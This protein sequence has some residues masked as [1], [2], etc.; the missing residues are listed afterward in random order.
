MLATILN[1][2]EVKNASGTEVEFTRLRAADRTVVY[3][4]VAE[5]PNMQHRLTVSH[6]E[7]GGDV[8]AR[9]RSVV[10]F[11]KEVAGVS[12][13]KRKVS[14]YLVVDA[15]VGD[16]A[17]SAEIKNVI[18]EVLSFCATTGAATT[19]LFDCTGNGAAALADGSL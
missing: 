9:R 11:D 19:V 14:A 5:P 6:Q 16:L 4:Q 1:T 17:T 18:A 15:P 3:Q 10:R 13:A 12:L 7:I 8:D 2:N